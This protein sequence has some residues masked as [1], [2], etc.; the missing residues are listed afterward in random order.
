MKL[1]KY[2]LFL[3]LLFVIGGAIFFGTKDGKFDVSETIV[4]NAPAEMIYDQVKDF[5]N[6]Q[7]W[8]P[9]LQIDP[10]I[11]ISQSKKSEG[12]GA[13]YS[14]KSKHEGLGNVSVETKK[15]IPLK[16]INQEISVKT[17]LGN[18]NSEV[19]WRFEETEKRGQTKVTWGLKGDPPFLEKIL[20]SFQKNYIGRGVGILLPK[21]LSNLNTLVIKKANKFVI[22]VDGIT[23]YDSRFYLYLTSASKITE[24]SSKLSQMLGEVSAF[25][26]DNNLQMK[27][28][29]FTIYNEIDAMNAT[30]IYSTCIPVG[31]KII[32]PAGSAVLCGYM[33]QSTA[34][35]TTL[36]GNYKYLEKAYY[37]ANEYLIA[38]S[39]EAHPTGKMFE[40]Y[41]NDPGSVP[42]PADWL[43]EVYIPI[44][45]LS[46]IEN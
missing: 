1:I 35:K 42:N 15:V 33:P 41:R 14:W 4:I 6:W 24:I 39:L 8:G 34:L 22:N 12:E 28:M 5:K 9:W 37:K 43:T 26:N 18:S 21:G 16:E 27:G 38:N 25:M 2:L 29:P 10:N 36:K 31:N 40:V 7:N 11:Q 44:V 30:A 3:I 19:Y 45:P 17:L 23:S 32:T 13:T 20:M 46:N